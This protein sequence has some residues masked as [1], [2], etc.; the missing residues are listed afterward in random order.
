MSTDKSD[1]IVEALHLSRGG[2]QSME[3]WHALSESLRGASSTE[4][5]LALCKY[6]VGLLDAA[7]KVI[8]VQQRRNDVEASGINLQ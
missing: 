5:H 6:C 1:R 7:R 4:C 3:T 8:E 2:P